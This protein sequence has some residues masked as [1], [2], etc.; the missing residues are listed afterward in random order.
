MENRG[1]RTPIHHQQ[2]LLSVYYVPNVSFVLSYDHPSSP[3][4]YPLEFAFS[5]LYDKEYD[6][7]RI[8]CFS[9]K[10]SIVETLI[11]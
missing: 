7:F 11:I 4:H 10:L 1:A 9:S 2:Y 6:V 8:L 5:R 3:L